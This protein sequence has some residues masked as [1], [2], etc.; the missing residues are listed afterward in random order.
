MSRMDE[1]RFEPIEHEE[2][3]CKSAKEVT[4]LKYLFYLIAILDPE[5]EYGERA[6]ARLEHVGQKVN[7]KH[8][9]TRMNNIFRHLI[10]SMPQNRYDQLSRQTH[11]ERLVIT[12]IIGAGQRG[13]PSN[14]ELVDKSDITDIGIFARQNVCNFCAGG[15]E[16]MR[17]CKFQKAMKHIIWEDRER[18]KGVC[19]CKTMIWGN[20]DA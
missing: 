5:G 18:I 14:L 4:Y 11:Q 17:K 2:M 12:P 7:Y 10:G 9:I 6:Q 1:R 13:D 15:A 3:P 19:M 8:T 16:D 20:D